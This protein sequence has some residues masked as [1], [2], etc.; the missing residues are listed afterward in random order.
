MTHPHSVTDAVRELQS[1]LGARASRAESVRE[2]HSHGESYHPAAAPDVVCFPTTT[3]E[4]S[5]ICT[6]SA[7]YGVPV[8]PFGAGSSLEGHVNATSGGITIDL[9]RMNRI[10]RTSVEDLDASVEAG[11]TRLQLNKALR[12]TGLTFFVDPGADCTLAA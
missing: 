8:V 2:Q 7:R 12:N 6:I 9:S 11:V 3:E 4:V 10:L 5:G 1:L